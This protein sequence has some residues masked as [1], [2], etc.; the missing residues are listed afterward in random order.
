MFCLA[1]QKIRH[2]QNSATQKVRYFVMI[3]GAEEKARLTP[4]LDEKPKSTEIQPFWAGL[5]FNA[6][7]NYYS[8]R[9]AKI[10]PP[11]YAESVK[12]FTISRFT[13]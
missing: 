9:K 7:A 12:K 1:R 2:P 11:N 3:F 5:S 10:C 4:A 13:A 6:L 8:T